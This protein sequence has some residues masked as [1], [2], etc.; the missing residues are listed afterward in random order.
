MKDQSG[1]IIIENYKR[2]AQGGTDRSPVDRKYAT[3]H[4]A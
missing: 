4:N 3:D 2:E 1:V